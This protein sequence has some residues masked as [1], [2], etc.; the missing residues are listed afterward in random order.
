[1]SI[2]YKINQVRN[3]LS[4]GKGKE[5]DWVY[6]YGL[7]RSGTTYFLHQLMKVARKGIGDWDL[8]QFDQVLSHAVKEDH[9]FLNTAPI[10]EGILKS[11]LQSAPPGGGN[12]FD[13]IVKQTL[14]S[15]GE[16]A[17]LTDLFGKSP[18][19]TIFF[20]REPH[21]WLNSAIKKYGWTQQKAAE[22]YQSGLATYRQVGGICCDYQA[23]PQTLETLFPNLTIDS[24]KPSLGDK[25]QATEELVKAYQSFSDQQKKPE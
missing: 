6:L 2:T 4:A 13:L 10:K 9:I 17:F 16:K 12:T 23:I 1:M 24:F 11:I 15:I 21:G 18:K 14:P 8:Y 25:K 7:P 3:L 20:Y 5:L 22:Q 19:H